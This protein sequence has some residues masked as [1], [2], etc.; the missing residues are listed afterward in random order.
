MLAA[1]VHEYFFFVLYMDGF[2]LY[3]KMDAIM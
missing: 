3:I 2:D 1:L